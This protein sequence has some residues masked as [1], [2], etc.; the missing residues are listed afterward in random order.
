VPE[1]VAKKTRFHGLAMQGVPRRPLL[2]Y[3][4]LSNYRSAACDLPAQNVSPEYVSELL[5]ARTDSNSRSSALLS[6]LTRCCII[7]NGSSQAPDSKAAV[8]KLGCR[9]KA[10]AGA[11]SMASGG[12]LFFVRLFVTRI[13][14]G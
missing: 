8:H 1:N 10:H 13:L 5:K 9:R 14:Q 12:N 11:F 2:S 6:P 7:G 3:D 4:A